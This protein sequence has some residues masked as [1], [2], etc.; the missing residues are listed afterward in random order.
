MRFTTLLIVRFFYFAKW[1]AKLRKSSVAFTDFVLFFKVPTTD[2]TFHTSHYPW[3]FDS[4]VKDSSGLAWLLFELQ[5]FS[6]SDGMSPIKGSGPLA[7]IASSRL[8]ATLFVDGAGKKVKSWCKQLINNL[9]RPT[10][11][12]ANLH[13]SKK[14]PRFIIQDTVGAESS[15]LFTRALNRHSRSLLKDSYTYVAWVV[16]CVEC[17]KWGRPI[18]GLDGNARIQAELTESKKGSYSVSVYVF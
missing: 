15:R 1:S 16:V 11:L 5:S 4:A 10:R 14:A 12:V 8:L 13:R 2:F 17:E 6:F 18:Q 9:R 3:P 7:F